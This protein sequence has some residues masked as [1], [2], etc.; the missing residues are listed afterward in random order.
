MP[1]NILGWTMFAFF[2]IAALGGAGTNPEDWE[3]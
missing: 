1:H 3:V 2:S